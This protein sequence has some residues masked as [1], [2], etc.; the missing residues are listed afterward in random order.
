[1]W[2]ICVHMYC[3]FISSREP[4]IWPICVHMYRYYN[5][6]SSREY[7]IGPICVHMYYNFISSVESNI[8]MAIMCSHVLLL[9]YCRII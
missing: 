7:I 6:I 4:D 5:F 9:Y 1:M 3:Y 2:P 8:W